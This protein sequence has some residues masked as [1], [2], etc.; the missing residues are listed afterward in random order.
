MSLNRREVFIATHGCWS[1]LLSKTTLVPVKKA[2]RQEASCMLM[3][4]DD[5]SHFIS[6]DKAV[7]VAVLCFYLSKVN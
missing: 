2:L 1:E 7:V 5:V 6:F 3:T 4:F